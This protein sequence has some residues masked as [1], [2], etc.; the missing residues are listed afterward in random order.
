MTFL[1]RDMLAENPPVLREEIVPVMWQDAAGAVHRAQVRVMELTVAEKTT[2]ESQAGILAASSPNDEDVDQAARLIRQC[3]VIASA[4]DES[5]Q[6]IWTY[7][8][9]EYLSGLGSGLIEPIVNAASRLSNF[10]EKDLAELGKNSAA[11]GDESSS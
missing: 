3:L 6:P 9:I 2:F 1:T 11:T 10:T 8:D 7:D 4:R 5:R